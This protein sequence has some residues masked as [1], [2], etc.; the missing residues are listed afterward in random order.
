[1]LNSKRLWTTPIL[2]GLALDILFWKTASAR[3]P[4]PRFAT[5]HW[6]LGDDALCTRR[7]AAKW[8]TNP[9]A[10]YTIDRQAWDM[11]VPSPSGMAF[12]CYDREIW[13]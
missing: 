4:V 3:T 5:A 12:D 6:L 13:D 1:M 10:G 8:T 7:T 9:L 2:L 11:I